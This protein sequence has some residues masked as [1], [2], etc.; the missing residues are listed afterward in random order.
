MGIPSYFSHIIRN[1]PNIVYSFL[2]FTPLCVQN[3]QSGHLSSFIPAHEVGVLNEERCKNKQHFQH[4]FMDCNSII[5]D[6]VNTLI[7]EK[8][9]INEILETK[10]IDNVIQKI[11]TYIQMVHPTQTIFIAFDGVA[12]F[13][14]MK[15][16]R[17]RRY[18]S[19]FLKTLQIIE[20]PEQNWDTSNITPG[21]PFMKKL[22]SQIH[23]YFNST[24]IKQKYSKN[25]LIVSTS[26]EIGEGEH[27]IFDYLRQNPCVNDNIIVYGLD[28][29]LIML[30]IFHYSL[31][32]NAY[33]WRESPEFGIDA[34]SS[35]T[36]LILDIE[37]LRKSILI[38]LKMDNPH[39]IYDYV[40]LCFFL[41]ND[42]L[43]H[44]PALNI[45]THGINILLNEYCILFKNKPQQFLISPKGYIEWE[46]VKK[47]IHVLSMKETTFLMEE[48]IY[49]EK[50]NS[51]K[52]NTS[53]NNNQDKILHNLPI[54][55][56]FEEQYISPNHIGWQERYY[57][58]LFGKGSQDK[59]SID[60]ICINYLEALEWVYNYYNGKT[61]DW[62]WA[63]K[64]HYGPLF[65]DLLS[66]IPKTNYF[67]FHNH[68]QPPCSEEEQL[69]YVLPS[70]NSIQPKFQWAFC[71][72]FWE[73]HVVFNDE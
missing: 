68:F 29:D 33:I 56:R 27:K 20:K 69:Q 4:L 52:W 25:N 7:K 65:A 15:Q 22:S 42:F 70:K 28:S 62:K 1:Y 57:L 6:V 23:F 9:I 19:Y 63:Y 34:I 3:T 67:Q 13:A 43:P 41:G 10:I 8:E 47:L 11:E 5:Y 51:W 35:N 37:L 17:T 45:R 66:H 12:P 72:Y 38:E 39:R 26:N 24:I 2:H 73:A 64:Y 21:T 30:T 71:R 36:M 58:T 14:K 59:Y 61:V 31:F 49:R 40:F 50:F 48:C 16:Q 60:D 18:K 53:N 32:K 44:F 55:Y 54:I 46:N